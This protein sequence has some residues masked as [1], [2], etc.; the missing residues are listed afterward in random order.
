MSLLWDRKPSEI[1]YNSSIENLFL[2]HLC[3]NW[4]NWSKFKKGC[5]FEFGMFY[6]FDPD[7]DT[8]KYMNDDKDRRGVRWSCDYCFDNIL[9]K[10][11]NIIII[12]NEKE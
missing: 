11:R 4:Y 3:N 10:N 12:N 6:K 2:C 1:N 5:L 8:Y 9:Y 7:V